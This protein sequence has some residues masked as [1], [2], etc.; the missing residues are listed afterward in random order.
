[1]GGY[2]ADFDEN[3]KSF[4]PAFL[5]NDILRMWRTF[6]VNYEY[7]RKK[8]GGDWRIKNLKLKYFRILT[9]FSAIA[10]I[11]AKFSEYK[12]V[13]PDDVVETSRL[14]PVQRLT[15][16]RDGKT[17][18]TALNLA[19]ITDQAGALL[20]DYSAFLELNHKDKA[21]ALMDFEANEDQWRRKSHEFGARFA[22]LLELIAGKE[23]LQ[24]PLYRSIVV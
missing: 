13:S 14:T 15:D 7:F 19:Q 17:F 5:F 24:N 2:F 22:A 16:L 10:H 20:E 8:G 18:S 12:T 1:M 3:Q 21:T 11:L 23:P 9:C 6:C 4:M